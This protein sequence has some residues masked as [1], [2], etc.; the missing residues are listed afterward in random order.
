MPT[1]PTTRKR[2]NNVSASYMT[3]KLSGRAGEEGRR[4]MEGKDCQSAEG[5]RQ[6]EDSGEGRRCSSK[7]EEDE[8][9]RE[10]ERKSQ[11]GGE[12]PQRHGA[13]HLQSL[14]FGQ[15]DKVLWSTGRGEAQG[16]PACGG[17][18][19]GAGTWQAPPCRGDVS[20]PQAT[21]GHPRGERVTPSPPPAWLP[22]GFRGQ[23]KSRP[24]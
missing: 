17:G 8:H 10:Q 19:R 3:P 1:D 14:S 24:Q 2:R 6:R 23:L 9:F 7:A 16:A 22:S 11:S 20:C 13:G 5:E 4:S 15:E 18:A 21:Q 12:E